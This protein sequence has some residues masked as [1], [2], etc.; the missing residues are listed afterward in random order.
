MT[1]ASVV[2]TDAEA[3]EAS[4]ASESAR[5]ELLLLLTR[6][7]VTG[8][9]PLTCK[10][11]PA[12][13]VVD[14]ERGAAWQQR[15][16]RNTCGHCVRLNARRRALAITVSGP[17][18]MIRLSSVAA[19]GDADPMATARTRIKR[20]RQAL[21]RMGIP[22]GEWCWTLERNPKG[23]GY[24]AHAVQRGSYVPQEGLQTA[25]ERAGAGIPYI[26]VI[27]GTPTATARYGLKGF[28]AAGYG[29]KTFG[30]S[31]ELDQALAI[32]HGRLE[33]HTP[34]FFHINGEKARV[35]EVES[36]GIA[37]LTDYRPP[38]TVVT[39]PTQAWD[40]LYGDGAKNR[41]SLAEIV[42]HRMYAQ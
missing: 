37:N 18:R 15:C 26:N 2:P 29:L 24:H 10:D 22:A 4:D 14:L 16:R 30:A 42:V 17:Q 11:A 34:G 40:L 7:T 19:A 31:E 21:V 9:P 35:R 28:G 25:C 20:M 12:L 33:H 36:H 38:I 32:N 6:Q 8:L 23:T 27:R 1:T 39:T 41:E 13:Y 5:R 3:T